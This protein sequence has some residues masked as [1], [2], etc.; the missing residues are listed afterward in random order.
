MVAVVVDQV[1]ILRSK[2]PIPKIKQQLIYD[3]CGYACGPVTVEEKRATY[4][5]INA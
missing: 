5:C 3:V 1:V 4:A 2:L